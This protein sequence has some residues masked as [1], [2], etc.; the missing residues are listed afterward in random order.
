MIP[1]PK[2]TCS[3]LGK[4]DRVH[5]ESD[6]WSC[7]SAFVPRKPGYEKSLELNPENGNAKARLEKLQEMK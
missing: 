4:G 6:G 7:V 1:Q 2:N 5:E 3:K